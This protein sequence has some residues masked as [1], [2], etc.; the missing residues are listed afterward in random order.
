MGC[1]WPLPAPLNQPQHS[2]PLHKGRGEQPR[3]LRGGGALGLW[4][5]A[6]RGRGFYLFKDLSPSPFTTSPCFLQFFSICCT[7]LREVLGPFTATDC[8]RAC[9]KL[10]EGSRRS[11]IESFLP[12]RSRSNEA[13]PT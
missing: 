3:G 11:K 10:K 13:V 9:S 8:C 12:W 2:T 7:A 4:L 5:M 6:A 1:R